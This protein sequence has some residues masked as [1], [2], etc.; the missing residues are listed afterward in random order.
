LPKYGTSLSDFREEANRILSAARAEGI[1]LRLIGALAFNVHCPKFA[2]MQ[3]M[4]GRSFSDLDFASYG[5]QAGRISRFFPELGYKEDFMVTRLFGRGRLLFHDQSEAKRHCDVFLDKLEFCH[6]ITFQGRLEIDDPTVPL[7]ELLLEKMQ[8]VRLNQKDIV[9]TVMLLREHAVGD[10]DT[11]TVNAAYIAQL[12]ARDW[13]L[14]KTFTTNLDVMRKFVD[15][16]RRLS[17]EDKNDVSSKLE[18]LLAR[19]NEK[20]K[21]AGW[22]L[23]ARVG[24]SRKWYRDV[25]ELSR[26]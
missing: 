22:K 8:I 17:E 25:E 7:A 16:E 13:G 26:V 1:L 4:L 20:P 14:W 5:N 11:E 19:V 21:T 10:S 6:D 24:E 18:K 3:Q 23:R 15:G 12:C 9:D 2:Y